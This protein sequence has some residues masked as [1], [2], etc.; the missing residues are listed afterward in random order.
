MR[1]LFKKILIVPIDMFS[2]TITGLK[3]F[4]SSVWHV[5]HSARARLFRSKMHPHKLRVCAAMMMFCCK[6]V[7]TLHIHFL[8]E[9]TAGGLL[10]ADVVNGVVVVV[11]MTRSPLVLAWHSSRTPLKSLK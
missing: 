4:F 2:N 10:V 1:S 8:L 5:L 9:S 3:T 6:A 11:V 7:C